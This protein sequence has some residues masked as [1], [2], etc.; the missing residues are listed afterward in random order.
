MCPAYLFF[1]RQHT[2]TDKEATSKQTKTDY[3]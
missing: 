3:G 1:T 2:T